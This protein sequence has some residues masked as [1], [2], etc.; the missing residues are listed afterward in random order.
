MRLVIKVSSGVFYSFIFHLWN[1][2]IF[3]KGGSVGQSGP[4]ESNWVDMALLY[5]YFYNSHGLVD[6]SWRSDAFLAAYVCSNIMAWIPGL[7]FSFF[8]VTLAWNT[9]LANHSSH[10]ACIIDLRRVCKPKNQY[11]QINL[12]TIV[13][14]EGEPNQENIRHGGLIHPECMLKSQ[15]YTHMLLQYSVLI[16]KDFS[17]HQT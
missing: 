1:F 2:S 7:N 5:I 15:K 3:E 13:K 10:H 17:L 6:N 8:N 16:Q 4:W 14:Y 11:L 9:P 12:Q